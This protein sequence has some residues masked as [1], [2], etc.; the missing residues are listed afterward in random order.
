M[1]EYELYR[2]KTDEYLVKKACRGDKQAIEHL[3]I[4]YQDRVYNICLKMTGNPVDAEDLC[5]EIFIKMTTGLSGFKGN[6]KFWTWLYR[7]T[8]NHTLDM[9]KKL[10]EKYF[11][12]FEKLDQF[13]RRLDSPKESQNLTI[14]PQEYDILAEETKRNCLTAMLLC[15]NRKQRMTFILGSLFNIESGAAADLMQT[16]AENFRKILSRTRKQL[17]KFMNEHCSLINPDC[18]C[19]CSNK[20][21][22]VWESGMLAKKRKILGHPVLGEINTFIEGKMDLVDDA[23]AVRSQ[24]LFRQMPFYK[25]PAFYKVITGILKNKEIEELLQYG[26]HV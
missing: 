14:S 13:S 11:C 16:S 12:S 7:I 22:A 1:R 25:S 4:R 23:L 3:I 9:K 5:Q 19:R 26:E 15:L 24:N 8:V 10:W 17:G 2:N 20:I 21:A 18:S 6:S